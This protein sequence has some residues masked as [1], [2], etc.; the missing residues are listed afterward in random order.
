MSSLNQFLS[1]LKESGKVELAS[2]IN[3]FTAEEKIAAQHLLQRFHQ[4]AS[5]HFPGEAPAFDPAAALWAAEYLYRSIQFILLR[6]LDE[7]AFKE[8]LLP[9]DKSQSPAVV[10]SADLC[11]QYLPLLFSFAKG[12][13][14]EDPLLQELKLT[15]SNWPF[16]GFS[17]ALAKPEA[18]ELLLS[19]PGLVIAYVDRIIAKKSKAKAQEAHIQPLIAVALG[20]YADTFWPGWKE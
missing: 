12:L 18:E 15:A 13:S 10:F 1:D 4:E 19:H 17:I 3:P 2:E 11:L 9:W 14:P 20:N 7:Q 6:H 5:L 8:H 16:S